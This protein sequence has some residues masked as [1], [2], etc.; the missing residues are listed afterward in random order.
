MFIQ[1]THFTPLE[2]CEVR[3]HLKFKISRSTTVMEERN[4]GIW[5]RTQDLP[6]IRQPPTIEP[7]PR[8][9]LRENSTTSWCTQHKKNQ[10][11]VARDCLELNDTAEKRSTLQK[12][13]KKIKVKFLFCHFRQ[14]VVCH[15]ILLFVTQC[16]SIFLLLV[17][18]L[19]S[20][21]YIDTH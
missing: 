14:K 4:N 12:N 8:T 16:C 3:N 20:Y 1:G 7:P 6:F 18:V 19:L 11:D 5:I 15:V 2:W 13:V 10:H 21:H 17:L 9:M